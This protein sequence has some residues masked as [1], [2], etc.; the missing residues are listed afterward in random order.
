METQEFDLIIAHGNCPDGFAAAWVARRWHAARGLNPEI[1]FALYDHAP[2]DVSNRDVLIADF[3]WPRG[4]LESLAA[5]AR[6]LVV[7]DHHATA[8]DA[9]SGLPFCTFDMDRSGA[10]MTW[11]Y[12]HPSEKRPWI[13][14]YTEDADLWRFALPHSRAVR[15]FRD[16]FQRSFDEWDRF[17]GFNLRDVPEYGYSI[18][19]ANERHVAQMCDARFWL[20]LDG[21]RVPAV[22]APV[23]FSDVREELLKREPSARMSASILLRADGKVQFGLGAREGVNA[24]EFAKRFGG[25]GHPGAAGFVSDLPTLVS[26]ME[27]PA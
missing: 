24:G 20:L 19:R 8:R 13:V 17:P 21:E 16:S 7:L 2:P 27:A 3:S 14:D 11:D 15:A 9:L 12:F 26:W 18:L 6:S 23:L 1:V 25:G 5:K 10:G 4:V 22:W